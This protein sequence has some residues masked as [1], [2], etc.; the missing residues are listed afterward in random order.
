MSRVRSTQR[1]SSWQPR[2]RYRPA[3]TPY[4]A[5]LHPT[6][7]L[8]T[9]ISRINISLH[10]GRRRLFLVD[11]RQNPRLPPPLR[12][13]ILRPHPAVLVSDPQDPAENKIPNGQL[14]TGVACLNPEPI[15]PRAGVSAKHGHASLARGWQWRDI[16]CPT[17]FSIPSRICYLLYM[18]MPKPLFRGIRKASLSRAAPLVDM[19]PVSSIMNAKSSPVKR[20]EYGNTSASAVPRLLTFRRYSDRSPA[21]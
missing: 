11:W 18:K 21:R 1:R 4:G 12:S 2:Q 17:T 13:P 10:H 14:K 8:Q 20:L 6:S 9:M 16:S 7:F 15:S 19:Q 3:K 5:T